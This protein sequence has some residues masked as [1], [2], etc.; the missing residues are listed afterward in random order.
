[1]QLIKN[2]GKLIGFVVLTALVAY[3]GALLALWTYEHTTTPLIERVDASELTL[4]SE[5]RPV[6]ICAEIAS[7]ALVA[8]GPS[9]C[10]TSSLEVVNSDGSLESL[11]QSVYTERLQGSLNE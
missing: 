6:D 5:V 2:I 7:G 9:S 11:K 3:F 10:D 4:I 1:M 8:V